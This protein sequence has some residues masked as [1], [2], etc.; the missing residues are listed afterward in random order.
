MF[1][2]IALIFPRLFLGQKDFYHS[3]P[4]FENT[5]NLPKDFRKSRC[6]L[7]VTINIF[8]AIGKENTFS[9]NS[10]IYHVFFLLPHL[11]V[12]LQLGLQKAEVGCPLAPQQTTGRDV[13]SAGRAGERRAILSYSRKRKDILINF[14]KCSNRFILGDDMCKV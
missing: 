14:Q 7:Y 13:S 10:S 12:D 1:I 2:V 5:I 4:D 9:L 3:Q 11:S 6:T 8:Q